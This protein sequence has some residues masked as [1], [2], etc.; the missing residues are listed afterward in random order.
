[1][2]HPHMMMMAVLTGLS[3]M[4]RGAGE[5]PAPA[6]PLA[7]KLTLKQSV[8]TLPAAMKGAAA[9]ERLKQQEGRVKPIALNA[10]LELTNT[11]NRPVTFMLGSD[12]SRVDLVLDGPGAVKVASMLMQTMEF[13]MGRPV[14]L[15]PGETHK[16]PLPNLQWGSRGVE[17]CGYWTEPG[18]YTLMATYQWVEG[19]DGSEPHTVKTPPVKLSVKDE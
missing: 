7:A 8:F 10:E 17:W 12:A 15:K 4:A 3:L 1:M 18:E 14:T 2:K 16:I 6:S 13:R 9:R 5:A 11:S 19:E